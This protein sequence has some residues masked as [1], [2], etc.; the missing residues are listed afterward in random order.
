ML[1]LK[2]LIN[3][4]VVLMLFFWGCE[5]AT[6]KAAPEK[7][8]I[9][10]LAQ[11]RD[12]AGNYIFSIDSLIK[13]GQVILERG[14]VPE[15]ALKEVWGLVNVRWGF[16]KK[17]GGN[18]DTKIYWMQ[19]NERYNDPK[20]ST[21]YV[22]SAP[23]TSK[24][25]FVPH[26][27][28]SALL[29]EK[30]ENIEVVAEVSVSPFVKQG[31]IGVPLNFKRELLKVTEIYGQ[32]LN[33]S[34]VEGNRAQG[35][36][37]AG[38]AV[39]VIHQGSGQIFQAHSDVN[40]NYQ[41]SV[42]FYDKFFLIALKEGMQPVVQTFT[43]LEADGLKEI[44]G[45]NVMMP[46]LPAGTSIANN[47][48]YDV[49]KSSLGSSSPQGL[50]VSG[51]TV[52]IKDRAVIPRAFLLF[53]NRGDQKIYFLRSSDRGEFSLQLPMD[54][55]FGDGDISDVEFTGSAYGYTFERGSFT[56]G[57][58]GMI[59]SQLKVVELTPDP[60]VDA[61]PQLSWGPRTSGGES[62]FV[63][64]DEEGKEK[65]VTFGYSGSVVNVLMDLRIFD[66]LSGG[67]TGKVVWKVD[68]RIQSGRS[69]TYESFGLD[70]KGLHTVTADVSNSRASN[71]ISRKFFLDPN[72]TNKPGVPVVH[73]KYE[74]QGGK[75][76]KT[77]KDSSG[78]EIVGIEKSDSAVKLLVNVRL[79]NPSTGDGSGLTKKWSLNGS[80]VTP[81][82]ADS[83]AFDLKPGDNIVKLEVSNAAGTKTVITT[84][85]LSSPSSSRTPVVKFGKGTS[86]GVIPEGSSLG[87]AD[88]PLVYPVRVSGEKFKIKVKPLVTDPVGG[89]LKYRWVITPEDG[90]TKTQAEET[91]ELGV[92]S[93]TI[94]VTVTNAENMFA[95]ASRSYK[96]AVGTALPSGYKARWTSR[97]SGG[98]GDIPAGDKRT[99]FG[100]K[101]SPV[102]VKLDADLRDAENV[103]LRNLEWYVEGD[104]QDNS[105]ATESFDLSGVRGSKVA[106]QVMII[107]R[108][109][110]GVPI[111]LRRVFTLDPNSD[112]KP[113][114]PTAEVGDASTGGKDLLVGGSA[115]NPIILVYDGKNPVPVTIRLSVVNPAGGT[116][117]Y[118]W[119]V[120]DQRQSGLD[121]AEEG[122]YLP[123][124]G[125]KTILGPHTA[126][127]VVSNDK[128]GRAIVNRFYKV[129]SLASQASKPAGTWGPR[130]SGGAGNIPVGSK[131]TTFHFDGKN[132]VSVRLDASKISSG[133]ADP[134]GYEWYVGPMLQKG[135][136][137]NLE[138]F[139]LLGEKQHPITVV[140]TNSKKGQYPLTR[141]FTLDSDSDNRPGN[142]KP[143]VSWNV[144]ATTPTQDSKGGLWD[145]DGS[146][147]VR[148]T[149]K[150]D[151]TAVGDNNFRYVWKVNGVAQ[152]GKTQAQVALDLTTAGNN[153]VVAEVTNTEG[154]T[155]SAARTYKLNKNPYN[156][157]VRSPTAGQSI[158]VGGGSTFDLT[159]Q[160]KDDDAN[161]TLT[162]TWYI[163]PG[164]GVTQKSEFESLRISSRGNSEQDSTKSYI[165]KQAAGNYTL[166]VRVNDT[167]G[168]FAEKTVNI[169]ITGDAGSQ[170]SDTRP[171]I[172]STGAG[173][174]TR[175]APLSN[176]LSGDGSVSSSAQVTVENRITVR[177]IAIRAIRWELDGT[178]QSGAVQYQPGTLVYRQ[179]FRIS[180]PAKGHTVTM[181]VT[182]RIGEE[183]KW[184][185]TYYLNSAPAFDESATG[186]TV[187]TYAIPNAQN[188]VARATDVNGGNL[189]Y[190]ASIAA[191]FDIAANS[192]RYIGLAKLVGGNWTGLIDGTAGTGVT[193]PLNF[194]IGLAAGNYTLRLVV[195]DAHGGATDILTRNIKLSGSSTVV[196]PTA[197]KIYWGAGT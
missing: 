80:P 78:N 195:T 129:I 77:S 157:S 192:N 143:I 28:P 48:L 123:V 1:R 37:V 174:V 39:F 87:T 13:D 51:S 103:W 71:S 12:S 8:S 47:R 43:I 56:L 119:Y 17:T 170:S 18:A 33:K 94:S 60:K 14:K 121:S 193:I 45:K 38:G 21:K 139:G 6:K 81:A 79:L 111:P 141:V 69:S 155:A 191:G 154:T 186:T 98:A 62:G 24:D 73:M 29:Q 55:S 36:A 153:V 86:G 99:T 107:G 92:G 75:V 152:S 58:G 5:E 189:R 128:G 114:D 41:V 108:D 177:T 20:D 96:V 188:I 35:R 100:Y 25:K 130:T 163:A 166:K 10:V 135:R 44:R 49:T 19:K 124:T 162:Y 132:A 133:G 31:T 165:F 149:A 196:S 34:A 106:R 63:P 11:S 178:A 66:P 70:G 120:D 150:V 65:T 57:Q 127:V 140:A 67:S 89:A 61:K 22:V 158:S 85:R 172:T 145:F 23:E 161:Q 185:Q 9:L 116:L 95:T 59:S 113:T 138:S 131:L 101:G 134:L 40:G 146:N 30:N 76:V 112:R 184:E 197:P 159:A 74:V 42:R 190:T 168:G 142:A 68:G 4:V 109:G 181:Y 104:L 97:S 117:S 64:V 125:G 84:Y 179:S 90:S 93:Y 144:A 46:E 52:S 53:Y 160:A 151:V 91:F 26:E 136:S 105:N 137:G 2:S 7:K 50:K 3:F 54:T 16:R 15:E 194:N 72:S 180:N 88:N 175:L 82:N 27:L 118:E 176:P 169:T 164:H 173:V 32:L 83:P 147:A 148:I 115:A 122:F 171:T 126:R 156:L 182:N 102:R 183:A 110:T 187:Q 167:D